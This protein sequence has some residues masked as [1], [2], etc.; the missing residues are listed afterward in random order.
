MISGYERYFQIARCFR[1][2]DTR[3]DRQPEFTQLDVEMAF[4][5]EE[6][7][8]GTIEQVMGPVLALGHKPA[9]APPYERMPYSEAISR[10][11]TDRPDRRFGL[12]LR[13]VSHELRETEFKVFAGPAND[14][15]GAV[16]AM[17]AGKVEMSR[18]DLDGLNSLAQ[19]LG[20][21]AVAWAFATADGWRSPIAKFFSEEQIAAVTTRMEATEGDLLIF[22]AD[23]RKI[24][25]TVLGG[26]RLEL[27]D[28]FGL[29]DESTHDVFWVVDFPMFEETDEGG[30]TPMH[31]P[32]SAPLG[33]LDGDPGDLGSRNY[34]LICD[35]SELG[36]GSIRIHRADVQQKVLGLI[37]MAQDEAEARF[38]FL[39]DALRY[40]APPHGGIAF[41]IDRVAAILS[42]SDSI[43]DV[44]AFPKTAT[45]ADPLTGAPS[46][47]EEAQLRELGLRYA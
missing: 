44:I 4:V 19:R 30:W 17:N 8:M 37:G 26:M 39:L 41:G 20:G 22:A 45:G 35:G 15:G 2:E 29:R 5:D 7:V 1:D 23:R 6:G 46:P 12:E 9:P 31:H 25:Q 27:A 38:G 43:R 14:P 11:G 21:K 47:I 10:F 32:F 16:L 18:S 42:G 3:A 33:D 34:D 36:G 40:G 28:R 13:D 24:A